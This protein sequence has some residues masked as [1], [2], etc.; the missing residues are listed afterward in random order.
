MARART[1]KQDDGEVGER[2]SSSATTRRQHGGNDEELFSSKRRSNSQY[3]DTMRWLCL[4]CRGGEREQDIGRDSERKKSG[5]GKERTERIKDEGDGESEKRELKGGEYELRLVDRDLRE[6]ASCDWW[7][8]TTA[9]ARRRKEEVRPTTKEQ[10]ER[11]GREKSGAS[12][13]RR[14]PCPH[15]TI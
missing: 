14:Y 2:T 8:A 1:T 9:A 15:Q 6:D 3:D 10:R 11:R 13:G 5:R 4:R 7:M 12:N